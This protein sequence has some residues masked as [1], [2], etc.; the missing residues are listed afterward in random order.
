MWQAAAGDLTKWKL[1]TAGGEFAPQLAAPVFKWAVAALFVLGLGF[2][3]GRYTSAT[4]SPEAIRAAIEPGLRTSVVEEVKRQVQAEIRA[5]WHAV[6][7]DT[8]AAINTDF[9]RELRLGLNQW[10]AKAV[11]SSRAEQE[12]LFLEFADTYKAEREQDRDTILTL[13]DRTEQKRALEYMSLRRAVET[14]AL[15]ADDRFQRTDAELGHL[16]SYTQAKFISHGQPQPYEG[17]TP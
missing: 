13:F 15:V 14:V 12:R 10:T 8:P 2:G 11:A 17:L 5:D 1:N 3:I 16:A 6:L 9:R 7:S 4:S